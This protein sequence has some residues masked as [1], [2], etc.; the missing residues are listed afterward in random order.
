MRFLS[1]LLFSPSACRRVNDLGL[2]IRILEAVKSKCSTHV[3]TI[4][5]YMIQEIKP[6]CEELGVPLPEEIGYDKP[7]L[8]KEPTSWD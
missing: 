3:D 6:T 7:E 8:W 2:A 1:I 4:W 5:P